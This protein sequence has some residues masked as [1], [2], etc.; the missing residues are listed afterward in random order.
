MQATDLSALLEKAEG[1]R[2]AEFRLAP[3]RMFFVTGLERENAK[4]LQAASMRHGF[5]SDPSEASA[6]IA[7]C[8]GAGACASGFYETRALAE[9]VLQRAAILADGSMTVHLSG[10]AKGCA[11]PRPTLTLT[12][13][14]GGYGIVLDGRANDRPDVTIAGGEIDLAIERLARLIGKNKSAG[15]SAAACLARL[16]A[17]AIAAALGQE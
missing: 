8:A 5:S 16:G 9:D 4:E 3:G 12:G 15:E 7:A 6:N 11:H 13:I 1:F 2:A 17:P 14:P 10:C